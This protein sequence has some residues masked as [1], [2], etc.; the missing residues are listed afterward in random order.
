[1]TIEALPVPPVAVPLDTL[2]V[3][4]VCSATASPQPAATLP[5]TD[6]TPPGKGRRDAAAGSMLGVLGLLG[7]VAVL[8]GLPARRRGRRTGTRP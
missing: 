7:L 4:S 5:A 1:V 6:T 3:S 2:L 8:A